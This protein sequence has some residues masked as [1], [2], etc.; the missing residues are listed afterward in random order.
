MSQVQVGDARGRGTVATCV[1]LWR[2]RG[3]QAARVEGDLRLATDP[4]ARAANTSSLGQ[5]WPQRQTPN[6][7][8]RALCGGDCWLCISPGHM[9]VTHAPAGWQEPD[10][11]VPV[12]GRGA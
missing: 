8:P 4:G 9:K 10:D 6:L 5:R 2:P 11:P 7:L 12:R 1:G 3:Q